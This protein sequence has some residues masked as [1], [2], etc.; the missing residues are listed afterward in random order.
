MIKPKKR[1]ID[2]KRQMLKNAKKLKNTN[3]ERLKRVIITNDMT[4]TERERS[5][6]L[7]E[8]LRRRREAGEENLTIRNNKIMKRTT[9]PEESSN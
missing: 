5:K 6:K 4:V 1:E 7:R 9:A 8:E 2:M 3:K